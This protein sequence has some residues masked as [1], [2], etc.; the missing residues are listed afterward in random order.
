[1]NDTDAKAAP[2][3]A[4]SRMTAALRAAVAPTAPGDRT[5]AWR[6]AELTAADWSKRPLTAA[7][8]Y[9]DAD[10]D[11]AA[12]RLGHPLPAA[13]REALKLFGRRD[14]LTRNQDPLA[15]PED[16][17]TYEGALVYREENQGVCA[18]G[19]MLGDLGQDDPPTYLRP[20]L[21][22]KSEEEWLPWT[23]RLSLALVEALITETIIGD[24]EDLTAAWEPGEE[25]LED[26]GLTALPRIQPTW[27]KTAWYVGDDVLAHVA[28]GAWISVKGRSREA[29]L[30]YTGGEDEDEDFD[31]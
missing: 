19:V 31:G 7:D 10:L 13:L 23:D 29:L 1:M 11:A 22:D 26:T 30:A 20:D 3:T 28:D 17:D 18:W 5:A 14:D 21:A 12:A 24:D 4:A 15:T 6:L 25:T 9:T 27:Y 2:D 16:L 8:G